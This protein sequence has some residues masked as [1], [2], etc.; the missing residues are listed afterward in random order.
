MNVDLIIKMPSTDGDP[1]RLSLPLDGT[2][3]HDIKTSL[4]REHPEHPLPRDQRLIFAGRLL[5]DSAAAADVL[6]QVRA[7]VVA[8]RTPLYFSTS[9]C[10][11]PTKKSHLPTTLQYDLREPQ[12]L[13]LMLPIKSPSSSPSSAA[14]PAPAS[15][16]RAAPSQTTVPPTPPPAPSS[17]PAP[18][19]RQPRAAPPQPQPQLQPQFYGQ[20]PPDLY[21][22][23]WPQF[24]G[25]PAPQPAPAAPQTPQQLA[26]QQQQQQQLLLAQQQ[27]QQQLAQQ[28]LQLP[29]GMGWAPQFAYYG[30]PFGNGFGYAAAPG[31][32]D[33]S[34]ADWSAVG[35]APQQAAA[36]AAAEQT[37]AAMAAVEAAHAEVVAAGGA[38]D[39]GAAGADGRADGR[40]DRVADVGLE[41]VG[42]DS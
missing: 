25:Q 31:W 21:G 32:A 15:A 33:W 5:P 1:L 37:R 19:P 35:M 26:Q 41:A 20:V 14:A 6:R 42:Y 30:Q 8:A 38:S 2:T 39:A 12:T 28:Q 40:A 23:A 13:H 3:V 9:L 22:Q 11:Q 34:G 18:Q 24:Y 27:Q 17:A 4:T 29:W 7:P 10:A 36:A 16:G